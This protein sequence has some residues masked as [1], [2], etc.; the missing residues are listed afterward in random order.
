MII[1]AFEGLDKSGKF[2]QSRLLTEALHVYGLNVVQ[3]EFHRYDT[4]TGELIAKW[5]NKEWD[6]DQPTIELIMAADKQAQQK[7]FK[8]LESQGVEVLILDRYTGSQWSYSQSQANGVSIEFAKTLQT[9]MRQPDLTVLLDIPAELSMARKGKHNNGKN[10]R[11]E[12]DKELL[13]RVR[14][15]FRDTMTGMDII[16]DGS[17]TVEH[18]H[19]D[20]FNWASHRIAT[21]KLLRGNL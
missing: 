4:P 17:D 18:M 6:V 20:I 7:W 14:Q 1:I 3:S 2:T 10:D 9:Y 21:R 5:L 19:E 13:E 12:E 8:E 11:Y 16:I 15:N